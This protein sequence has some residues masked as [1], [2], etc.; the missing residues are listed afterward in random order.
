MG[1]QGARDF[2]DEF[3][4]AV[5]SP[6]PSARTAGYILPIGDLGLSA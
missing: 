5:A 1:A 6:A 2:L 4:K 3:N